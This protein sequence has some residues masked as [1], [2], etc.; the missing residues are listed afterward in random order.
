MAQNTDLVRTV[1]T[2]AEAG[3]PVGYYVWAG[4]LSMGLEGPLLKAKAYVTTQQAAQFLRMS[5]DAGYVPAL[6][7]LGL[8][9]YSGRWVEHDPARAEE[10][11]REAEKHGSREATLRLAVMSVRQD[12]AGS[13]LEKSLA[14]LRNASAN[15]AVLADV[16]LG[17][18]YEQG[19]MVQRSA[20]AAA[21]L[22][23]SA[24]RRGSQDAYR[25]LRR[26]HDALRPGDP[27][28]AMHD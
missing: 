5:F 10:L 11:W 7:E 17:Y 16:A 2:R 12:T 27:Q 23:Q 26:L 25:A 4:L 14:V 6:I 15:G 13:R 1:K 20:A 22:Y 3:D 19:I 18:C 28:F 8:L 24:W 9:Y 21:E